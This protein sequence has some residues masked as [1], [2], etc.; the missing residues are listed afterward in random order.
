VLRCPISI[1]EKLT[2]IVNLSNEL[3][4]YDPNYVEE[5][6]VDSSNYMEDSNNEDED[7]EFYDEMGSGD[8]FD[9]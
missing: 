2:D 9:E 1:T 4:K 7:N 6:D 3:I 8:E 5:N